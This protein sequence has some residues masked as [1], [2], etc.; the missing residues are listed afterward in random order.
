MK[1]YA[2]LMILAAGTLWGTMGVFV[3]LL[4]SFGF[5]AMQAAALRIESAAILY[6]IFLFVKDKK[7]LKI[8]VR[9]FGIF[10]A[11]GIFSIL[12]LTCFYF[13]AIQKTSYSVAAILL[14][15]APIMV[16]IMSAIFFKESFGGKK[17]AALI[18][19]FVGCVLVSGF[20]TEGAI[21]PIGIAF[22]LL[23]GFAYALYSIF[24]KSALKR[25]S[26]LTVSAY[27]FIFAGI[28]ALFICDIPGV[29]AGFSASP[30]K[31]AIVTAALAAGLVTAFLPF[32]FYTL[33]LQ[34]TEPGRASIL[35][36]VEPLVATLCG[37]IKGQ[38]P[39]LGALLGIVCILAAVLVLTLTKKAK[40]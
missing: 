39:T 19:A 8:R 14:Y 1:K 13:L 29:A 27:A 34:N 9:D 10:F 16:S 33:G 30:H 37:F 40:L 7:L 25:Y 38:T 35:A 15:T 21:A 20:K 24:G 2:P 18:C 31:L 22:G 26:P 4:A 6:V 12:A 3:D 32:V 28:G 11:L 36:S 5:N 23:S 17:I